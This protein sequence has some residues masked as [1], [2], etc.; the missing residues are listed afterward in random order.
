MQPASVA[1][2]SSLPIR[3]SLDFSDEKS[4]NLF[5]FEQKYNMKKNDCFNLEK[6]KMA[7][8][9][10]LTQKNDEFETLKAS[11]QALQQKVDELQQA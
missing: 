9:Q 6:Q 11:Y 3:V 7:L 2:N 5:I 4:Q 8:Q 10:Q 1:P